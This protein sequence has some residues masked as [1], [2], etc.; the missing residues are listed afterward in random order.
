MADEVPEL[1]EVMVQEP[2][3]YL[4]LLQVLIGDE[5]RHIYDKHHR[6]PKFHISPSKPPAHSAFPGDQ[7][8]LKALYLATMEATKKWRLLIWDWA[9]SM[10]SW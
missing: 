6:E 2:G 7:A 4:A 5:A 10:A 3:C 1:Y 8:L 9:G